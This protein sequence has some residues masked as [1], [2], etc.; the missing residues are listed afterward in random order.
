MLYVFGVGEVPISISGDPSSP[1]RLVHTT[2][3]V[4]PVTRSLHALR[5]GDEVRAERHVSSVNFQAKPAPAVFHRLRPPACGPHHAF[6]ENIFP[7]AFAFAQLAAATGKAFVLGDNVDT[8]QIIPAQYLTYDP[9]IP[10]EYRMF[11]K[12]G[13]AELPRPGGGG[14]FKDRYVI[15]FIAG[16][17]LDGLPPPVGDAIVPTWAA[18]LNPVRRARPSDFIEGSGLTYVAIGVSLQHVRRKR[19]S[20]VA[21]QTQVE[22]GV[23]EQVCKRP[24]TRGRSKIAAAVRVVAVFLAEMHDVAI[25][26]DKVLFVVIV[27]RPGHTT[28]GRHTDENTRAH[29]QLLS[30][31]VPPIDYHVEKH[32][33]DRASAPATSTP[34]SAMG[35]VPNTSSLARRV[36]SSYSIAQTQ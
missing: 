32:M 4:G 30:H 18:P 17:P 7:P 25:G 20:I 15:S 33:P 34:G 3:V 11:G 14:Y 8:D 6:D 23:A 35:G 31:R 21:R 28:H 26:A 24:S 22:D 2:R 27:A 13:T 16:A 1:E 12:S 36:E 5:V 10:E 29:Q 9:S 19:L